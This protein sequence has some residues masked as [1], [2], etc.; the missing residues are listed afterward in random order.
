MINHKIYQKQ[1]NFGHFQRVIDFHHM[2]KNHIVKIFVMIL[3]QK[4]INLKE[5]VHLVMER[6]MILR[7]S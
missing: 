5:L 2:V 3:I 4:F 6:N 1:N 7:K